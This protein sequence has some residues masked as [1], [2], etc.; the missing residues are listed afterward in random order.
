MIQE[1]PHTELSQD[2]AMAEQCDAAGKHTEAVNHL[3][4]GVR[5]QDVEA[6][7]RLGK[8]LLVGD[9]APLL[10]NDAVGLLVEAGERG[11]A[12]AAAIVAVLFGI[13]VSRRHGLAAAFESLVRAAERGWRPAQA[14]L[15]VIAGQDD[16]PAEP[17]SAAPPVGP[18]EP[19]A[20]GMNRACGNDS[21]YWRRL[22]S[23]VDLSAWETPLRGTDL[24]GEP[25]IRSFAAFLPAAACRWLVE[26]ARP[27]LSRARIYEALER[28]N[29]VH[30][31]RTNRAAMFNVLTTDFVLVL[32]QRRMAACLDLP[33]SHLEAGTVL[34][35]E[36]GQQ[37]IDHFDFVDPNVPGYEEEI[38]RNGQRVFTFLVYLNDDYT[39]GETEFTRLGIRH[40]GRAGD[41]LFFSN[42]LPDGSADVRTLHAGRPTA[43]GQKW[44]V[45]QFVRSRPVLVLGGDRR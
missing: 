19:P 15:A 40:K 33:F 25:L 27:M 21:A 5:K 22:A 29:K 2:V 18:A 6:L 17:A 28:Q 7:T 4:A 36:E 16:P 14:Q 45:S 39:G 11:G 9:R 32:M 31:A 8:R 35:Y 12:E 13:G 41:A 44:I 1:P 37:I 10:P 26:R 30:P 43:H 34:H 20:A 23:G 38:A 24:C 3:V 42:A